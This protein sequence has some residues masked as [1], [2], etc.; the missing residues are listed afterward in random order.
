VLIVVPVIFVLS[1]QSH[2]FYD[3]MLFL[4]NLGIKAWLLYTLIALVF[5]AF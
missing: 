5:G 2:I 3:P 1:G 4:A